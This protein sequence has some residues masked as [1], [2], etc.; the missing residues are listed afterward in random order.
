MKGRF[1][2]VPPT[3]KTEPLALGW[4]AIS[5]LWEEDKLTRRE[6]YSMTFKIKSKHGK[7]FRTLRF[8][9]R[10]KGTPKQG[11]GQILIDWHGWLTVCEDLHERDDV[12]LTITRANVLEVFL[13]STSHPDPAYRHSMAVAR[14]GLYIGI[15][16][17][18]LAF[19]Q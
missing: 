13:H 12:E 19:K 11:Q 4:F 6:S 15:I 18:I 5:H 3:D 9:P 17:L 8:S 10:L 1:V 7:I 14:T 16:S 2:R